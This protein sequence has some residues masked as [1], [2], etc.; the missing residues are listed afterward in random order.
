MNNFSNSSTKILH[1]FRYI[2]VMLH[3]NP[4]S[5][6]RFNLLLHVSGIYKNTCL[7][8]MQV[9]LFTYNSR[10]NIHSNIT[11]QLRFFRHLWSTSRF[12]GSPIRILHE[13][14][15][16]ESTLV[17]SKVKVHGIDV[18]PEVPHVTCHGLVTELALLFLADFTRFAGDVTCSDGVALVGDVTWLAVA[19]EMSVWN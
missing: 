19:H 9:T 4:K 2:N 10:N 8:K 13:C 17:G 14:Q 1:M 18:V 11:Y 15:L 16:T 12:M 5:V 6:D 3:Q 7:L